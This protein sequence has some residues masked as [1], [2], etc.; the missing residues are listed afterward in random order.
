MKQ[1]KSIAAIGLAVGVFISLSAGAN[2]HPVHISD[3]PAKIRTQLN[4]KYP[5]WHVYVA[6]PARLKECDQSDPR[7]G[8]VIVGDFNGDGAQDYAVLVKY[9]RAAIPVAFIRNGANY[10]RY[11]L[12]PADPYRPTG[13]DLLFSI[14]SGEFEHVLRPHPGGG[15]EYAG[16]VHLK[17]DGIEV[18]SCGAGTSIYFIR[19]GAVMEFSNSD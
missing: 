10:T 6:D 11:Q 13:V 1:S 7:A 8:S 5:G 9:G 2:Q 4:E 18:T 16:Q 15:V 19:N 14:P 3:I 17:S 12:Y